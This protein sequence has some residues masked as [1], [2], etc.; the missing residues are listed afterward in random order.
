MAQATEISEFQNDST[1]LSKLID[2]LRQIKEDLS[3]DGFNILGVF[4]SYARSEQQP[5][6]DI[7]ILYELSSDFLEKYPG[8]LGVDKLD[9]IKEL[10][11]SVLNITPDTV[12]K[13]SVPA[14]IKEKIE[15]ELI[16]V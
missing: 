9:R 2:L 14:K 1:A 6:S 13:S 7:D 10:L 12:R 15:R 5:D 11:H 8:F 16:S 3:C 4:G